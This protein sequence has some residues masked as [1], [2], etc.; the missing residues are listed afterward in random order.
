MWSSTWRRQTIDALD[1]RRE[2]SEHAGGWVQVSRLGNPLVNEVVIPLGQ[3]DKFNATYPVDDLANFGTYVLNPELPG[4]LNALFGH[5]G[6]AEAAQRP[7]RPRARASPASRSVRGEVISDQLRLNTAIP[8]TPLGSHQPPR[9][10]RRATTPGSR[11]AG[12]SRTTPWTSRCASSPGS[13]WTAS[14][15]R[16]TTR[17]ATASTGRTSRTS[18]ASRT[19]RRRTRGSTASTPTPPCCRAA[20]S[21]RRVTWTRAERRHRDRHAGRRRRQHAG[22][23]VLHARQHR[24]DG[25]GPR[26]PRRRRH[27]WVFYGSLTNVQFTLTVTDRPTGAQKVYTSPQGAERELRR[28]VRRSERAALSG[29]PGGPVAPLLL[30]KRGRPKGPPPGFRSRASTVLP[31]ATSRPLHEP[32]QPDRRDQDRARDHDAPPVPGLVAKRQADQE[33]RRRRSP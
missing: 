1:D 23:L 11:T 15:S 12:A 10:A 17:S 30:S 3:K 8:A 19:S 16:R 21:R 26:R 20:V 4:I 13:W 6:P 31:P 27:F 18:P 28:H 33:K 24:A 9:R 2:P 32:V 5:L 25:E 14:T 29:N 22:I 7:A